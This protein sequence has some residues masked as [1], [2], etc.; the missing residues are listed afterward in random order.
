MVEWCLAVQRKAQASFGARA[1]LEKGT[2]ALNCRQSR[3]EI[4]KSARK[5]I[6]SSTVH[7]RL[8]PSYKPQLEE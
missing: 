5:S 6:L 8:T 1:R 7:A 4:C 3:L 2:D